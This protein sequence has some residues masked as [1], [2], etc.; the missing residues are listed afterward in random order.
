MNSKSKVLCDRLEMLN[1]S[2]IED[3]VR[4]STSWS[5]SSTLAGLRVTGQYLIPQCLCK[6]DK[7][8]KLS[9]MM[10]MMSMPIYEKYH[11]RIS[12]QAISNIRILSIKTSWK[13][14]EPQMSVLDS[15]LQEIVSYRASLRRFVL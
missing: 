9:L 12:H 7:E 14:L 15:L 3:T 11:L 10:V 6:R 2:I 13:F 5:L 8:G 1:A 4:S